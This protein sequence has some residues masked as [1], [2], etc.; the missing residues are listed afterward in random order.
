[1]E[2]KSISYA[3]ISEKSRVAK[4]TVDKYTILYL[5][6]FIKFQF[7]AVKVSDIYSLID[8]Y[9]YILIIMVIFNGNADPQQ[10]IRWTTS[11]YP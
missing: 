9:S 7:R 11:E 4:F 5:E 1:M 10:N 6:N 2:T 3:F 8:F